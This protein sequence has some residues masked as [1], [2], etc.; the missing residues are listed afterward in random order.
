LREPSTHWL[1]S[2]STPPPAASFSSS[3]SCGLRRCNVALVSSFSVSVRIVLPLASVVVRVWVVGAAAVV[4]AM[5]MA[6]AVAAVAVAVTVVMT[7]VAAASASVAA[8][9]VAVVV[10][11]TRAM[12]LVPALLQPA[13][14]G[15]GW[16]HT[17]SCMVLHVRCAGMRI[18]VEL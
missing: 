15:W 7:V 9:A 16:C 17:V 8:A 13:T 4:A 10:A 18:C 11:V 12:V 1:G 3:F 5:A 2:V 6:V 14:V